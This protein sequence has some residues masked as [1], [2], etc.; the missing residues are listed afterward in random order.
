M[1]P[2]K[3]NVSAAPTEPSPAPKA[4]P[5][6]KD[7]DSLGVE[8]L[9]LPKSI[10]QR[11]A[12]G[13]LPPNTQIQKDALL[14][15]SKS[16]TVFVSYITSSA[17]E[18]AERSGKKTVNPKDVFGAMTELE[19]D[20]FLPRLE[21]EVTKF[22]SIQADKRNTYRKKVRE[23]KKA[24]TTA[25]TGSTPAGPL[26]TNGTAQDAGD[27]PPAAKRARRESGDAE[28]HQSG[29]EDE[30]DND[31]TVDVEDEEVEDDEIEE[32]VVE[33]GLTED[34]L[35]ER[36]DKEEDDEMADGDESD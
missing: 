33:E 32:E 8:D 19:F 14:A 17:I 30:G 35:E 31:E 15:M 1:P 16:A 22:T 18:Y 29:S 9:N 5:R 36:E 6:P 34:P 11:L 2:R 12:K 3:S 27:S 21:A 26:N 28:A 7:D 20:F 23:E 13:V 25:T 10:V 24:A 4:A